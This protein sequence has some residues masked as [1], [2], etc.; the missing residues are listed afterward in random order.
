[1]ECVERAL[2]RCILPDFKSEL[3]RTLLLEAKEAV[4][5]ACC[6]K[7]YNWIKV[8]VACQLILGYL[9]NLSNQVAPYKVT[10]EEEDDDWD[11]SKGVRVMAIAYVPDYTQSAFACMAAPDGD[12]TDYLRLPHLLKRINSY[13]EDEKLMKVRLLSY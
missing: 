12:I 2:T 7:L 13:R 5:K 10:F 11:T 1:M 6:R 8:R 9:I 3:K 4:L